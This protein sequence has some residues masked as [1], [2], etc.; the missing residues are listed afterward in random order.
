MGEPY[1]DRDES[2]P[3]PYSLGD[4]APISM[5]FFEAGSDY[6]LTLCTITASVKASLDDPDS[7]A[8]FRLTSDDG[9]ALG[10]APGNNQALFS[11]TSAQSATLAV[12]TYHF[13]VRIRDA[14]NVVF[15]PFRGYLE[16]R[17]SGIVTPA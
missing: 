6:D 16:G 3:I 4:S 12:R 2:D 13:T 1:C 17:L 10:P 15:T 8:L 5:L 7:A 9:I 14:N 11:P